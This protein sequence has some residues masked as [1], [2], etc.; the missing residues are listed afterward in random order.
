[1][2]CDLGSRVHFAL[3]SVYGGDGGDACYGLC[4]G[5]YGGDGA[6]A[7][8]VTGGSTAIVAG[9]STIKG[10]HRGIGNFPGM[11]ASGVAVYA[12]SHLRWSTATI[13]GGGPPSGA[14]PPIALLGG[15]AQNV[16]PPDPTLAISGNAVAGGAM[17]LTFYG[18]P[19]TNG[20][21]QQGNQ[22]LVDVDGLA[23]IEKLN[24]R[25]RIHP[26]GP[27]PASGTITYALTVPSNWVPGQFRV[28]Q[29]L[30]IDA[31]SAMLIERT[32]SVPVVVH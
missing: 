29:G 22:M 11:R 8:A 15:T 5:G 19:G 9:T 2:R 17:T 10:G 6:P 24:N 30:E 18:L 20:R 28:F 7:I 21:L 25:I 26:L 4:A 23:E 14:P 13:Q 12:S 27:V 3:T 1:V 32:N 16:S 31:S